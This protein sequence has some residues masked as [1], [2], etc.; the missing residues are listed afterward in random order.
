MEHPRKV[1]LLAKIKALYPLKEGQEGLASFAL[2][3]VTDAVSAYCNID[4]ADIPAE[5][6]NGII[7]MAIQEIDSCLWSE[8]GADSGVQSITEGDVSVSFKSQAELYQALQESN[9]ITDNYISLL[10]SYRV[11]SYD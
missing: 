11:L 9:P 7:G 10:N 4:A 6:D 2:D 5:L 1:D 3:K 8:N